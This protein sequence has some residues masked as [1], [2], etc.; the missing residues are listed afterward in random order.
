LPAALIPEVAA[1]ALCAFSSLISGSS[2]RHYRLFCVRV[3]P[4]GCQV[5][6]YSP[7]L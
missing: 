3:N 7:V 4:D 2:D 5:P 1:A 6:K